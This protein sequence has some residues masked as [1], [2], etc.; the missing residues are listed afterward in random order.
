MAATSDNQSTNEPGARRPGPISS[1]SEY[2]LRDSCTIVADASRYQHAR[3]TLACA[4]RDAEAFYDLVRK[5][6]G[7]VRKDH[8]VKLI[9]EDA[10]T[11][12]SS[13]G[14]AQCATRDKQRGY[15]P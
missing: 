2:P 7:G 15:P 1:A 12:N 11:R 9:D 8:I 3:W 10:A 6:P 14:A 4:H 5:P 13:P